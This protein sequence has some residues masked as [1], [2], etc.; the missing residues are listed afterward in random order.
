MTQNEHLHAICC[1]P[2]VASDVIS[3]ENAKTVEGYALLYFAVASSSSFGDIQ[4]NHFVTA[5]SEADIND[6]IKRKRIRI[7][8]KNA[9]A[10]HSINDSE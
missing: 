2:E 8:L 6:S 7:S 1:R 9:F 3:C 10:F 5:E 4:R